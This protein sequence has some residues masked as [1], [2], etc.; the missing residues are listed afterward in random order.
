M[1][2]AQRQAQEA[3]RR[4]QELLGRKS[5]HTPYQKGQWVW[6]DGRHLQTTHPSV[7]MRPKHFGPFQVTETIGKTTYRLDLPSHWKVHNVFHTN[8]LLPYQE[9]QEHRCNFAEPPPELIEGQE[10][11]EVEQILDRRLHR[12]KEQCLIKWKGYSDTHNSWELEENVQAPVL[13]LAFKNKEGCKL[14][15]KKHT[16]EELPSCALETTWGQR[17]SG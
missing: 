3:I 12:R 5:A 10:E 16:R 6:L 1:V 13:I 8:L 11:W 15:Q 4:A 14:H 7:K 17:F 2:S 9:T